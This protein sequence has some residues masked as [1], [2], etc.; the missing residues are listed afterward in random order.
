MLNETN[1]IFVSFCVVARLC[2]ALQIK[3][4][5]ALDAR[6]NALPNSAEQATFAAALQAG[7]V[8]FL[9]CFAVF[10]FSEHQNFSSDS[11]VIIR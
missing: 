2:V 5:V 4:I 7:F 11:F 8:F 3:A 1:L 9:F 6:N 10:L